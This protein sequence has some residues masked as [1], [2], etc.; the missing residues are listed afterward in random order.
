MA[1]DDKNLKK[2]YNNFI[3]LKIRN[4]NMDNE[5]DS[6]IPEDGVNTQP[7]PKQPKVKAAPPQAPA[8]PT[9]SLPEIN[10]APVVKSVKTVKPKPLVEGINS[11]KSTQDIVFVKPNL[12]PQEKE[13]IVETPDSNPNPNPVVSKPEPR[14]MPESVAASINKKNHHI[15]RWLLILVVC[16]ILVAGAY[17]YYVW[18]LT[19]HQVPVLAHYHPTAADIA[20]QPF[21]LAGG[22]A[23]T[24]S[25]STIISASS[26]PSTVSTSTPTSTPPS[27]PILQVKINSTPTGYLNVRNQPSS[28]ATIVTQVHPGEVYTYVKFQNG[29]YEI[30]YS[31]FSQ[32]WV[33]GQYVTKQ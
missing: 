20:A 1:G 27:A 4:K 5:M 21:P 31:G 8:Q 12:T 15:G 16:L 33:S 6:I 9:V 3:K 32:G 24:S 29:W 23:P 13:L 19:R 30:T 2:C 18:N 14:L 10:K 11:P 7:Q 25:T 17:E 28:S 26:T 22:T